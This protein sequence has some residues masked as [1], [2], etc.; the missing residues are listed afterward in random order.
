MADFTTTCPSDE[1]L[2]PAKRVN[3]ELGMV[4]GA[5]D[6]RAEQ[7]YLR[8][9]DHR[10][11]RALHG[12]GTIAGLAVVVNG[13]DEIE[14]AP[15]LA[16]DP[17]GRFICVPRAQCAD[18]NGWISE[19][20]DEILGA[21]VPPALPGPVDIYVELCYRECLTDEVPVPSEDCR[22]ADDAR[23]ASR[24]LDSFELRFSVEPTEEVGEVAGTALEASI[25]RL[26]LA[27][28]SV[29]ADPS[30]DLQPLH[31]ELVSW[32]TGDRPE[33]TEAP[34]LDTDRCCVQ[35]VRITVPVDQ[36]PSGLVPTGPPQIDGSE[37]SVLLSTRYLQEWLLA[38]AAGAGG[39]GGPPA[40]PFLDEL[41]DV[42][43]AGA[44]DGQ[45]IALDN[46]GIWV[47]T[48]LPDLTG[49][50][51]VGDPAGGGL[52]GT[53][54]NPGVDFSGAVMDGDPAGGG[55][56]GTYPNPGVD[57]SGAVM[58][59]DA[60][61][62]DLA[63]TYPDPQVDGLRGRPIAPAAPTDGDVLVFSAG[64]WRPQP[65]S[66]GGGPQLE[67]LLPFATIV[68][69]PDDAAGSNQFL[70]WFHLD[71][72]PNQIEIVDP[73]LERNNHL[74]VT[75]ET[76]AG[77]QFLTSVPFQA[78]SQVRRNVYGVTL[79]QRSPLLRFTFR[80]AAIQ[81]QVG[82]G[83]APQQLSDIVQSQNLVFVGQDGSGTVTVFE[84]NPRAGLIG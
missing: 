78:A 54:P 35:L 63:G 28:S 8:S 62:G 10:G 65:E 33:L 66:A 41:Q 34:C 52:T 6:F 48:D 21:S 76:N 23:A 69:V 83:G 49:V 68:P 82:V 72:A 7:Y 13:D 9:R 32:V 26:L 60:A 51:R 75:R 42:A 44:T 15:G 14:V 61:G 38:I 43:S 59:G 17:V 25:G 57:L 39:P 70:I 22:P 24:I 30:A 29:P 53:Y 40:F 74:V 27:A 58:D 5:D 37:R 11:I 12:Y 45:V 55:L 18:L 2:D 84:P 1:P 79:A 46:T 64:A 71:A 73:R 31:D 67:R 77:P 50:I 56:T 80:L 19:H 3:Y 47:P 81:V 16:V 36:G 20:T 4:L